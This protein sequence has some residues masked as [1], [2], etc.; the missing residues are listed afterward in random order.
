MSQKRVSL[1]VSVSQCLYLISFQASHHG[2]TEAQRLLGQPLRV[3]S[4]GDIPD[5][6][7]MKP[8]GIR[9]SK[10]RHYPQGR[11]QTPAESADSGGIEVGSVCNTCAISL[12]DL[13]DKPLSEVTY[14]GSLN[15][16]PREVRW[17]PLSYGGCQGD[18]KRRDL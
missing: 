18:W 6:S 2:D 11:S 12:P 15:R 5:I 16:D 8:S 1:R 4:F 7:S 9:H 17:Y 10:L 14:G 3:S 13:D